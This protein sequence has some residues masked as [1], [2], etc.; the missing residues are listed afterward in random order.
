MASQKK[1]NIFLK[2]RV[3]TEAKIASVLRKTTLNAFLSKAIAD[4]VEEDKQVL[5]DLTR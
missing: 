4:A 3:H 1:V 2:E 5:L